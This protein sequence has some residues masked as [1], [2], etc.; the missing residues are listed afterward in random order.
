MLLATKRYIDGVAYQTGLRDPKTMSV[1]RLSVA[2]ATFSETLLI[3]KSLH[4]DP[5]GYFTVCYGKSPLFIGNAYISY[6]YMFSKTVLDRIARGEI[7]RIWDT[8]PVVKPQR[9]R[10]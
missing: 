9:Q 3:L 1:R 5:F 10:F 7:P 2:K 6:I 4:L 8:L